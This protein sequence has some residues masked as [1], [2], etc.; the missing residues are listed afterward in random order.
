MANLK[1]AVKKHLPRW[2]LVR[3][4][5]L[6]H[7]FQVFHERWWRDRQEMFDHAHLVKEWDFESPLERERYRK[8]LDAIARLYPDGEGVHALEV[9]CSEGAFTE[10]LAAHCASVTACD[11]SPVARAGASKRCAN[12]PN[13]KIQPFDL[14]TDRLHD[15]YN[16]V[17]AMDILDYVHGRGSL[18]RAVDKLAHAVKQ[19]GLLIFSSCRVPEDL[20]DEWWMPWLP[21]GADAVIKFMNGRSGLQLV[22][23]EF[24]PDSEKR[25]AGYPEHIIAIFKMST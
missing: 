21:E 24:F 22:H 15:Q 16:W 9:G 13:V 2:F 4:R 7:F 11:M 17:F 5:R 25:V 23:R 18:A 14:K 6:R 3:A 20:R 19:G 10:K 1:S 8:V 12:F